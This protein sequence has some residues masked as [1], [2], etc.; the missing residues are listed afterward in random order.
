MVLHKGK[1]QFQDDWKGKVNNQPNAEWRPP[2]FP[3]EPF[4]LLKDFR[5]LEL[6]SLPL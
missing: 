2:V 5:M 6:N 1:G 4:N 3:R